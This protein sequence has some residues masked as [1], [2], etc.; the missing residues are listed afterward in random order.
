VVPTLKAGGME[1][2][3]SSLANIFSKNEGLQLYLITLTNQAHFFSLDKKVKFFQP[4]SPRVKNFIF[5]S[6]TTIAFLRR[7]IKKHKPDSILSFGD[8]YNSIVVF[9]GLLSSSKIFISNR[10]NPFQSNGIFI[11]TLNRLLYPYADG[12]ICQTKIA[13]KVFQEKYAIKNFSVIPNPINIQSKTA[14]VNCKRIINVGRFGDQK[15]QFELVEIFNQLNNKEGWQLVFFGDGAKKEKTLSMI[16]SLNLKKTVHIQ[17]FSNSIEKEYL[18]SSIFAFTSK[19]EGFP[20][21]LAEAMS[22]GCACISFDCVAG[23]SDIIDDGVN[24]FLIP[25]DDHEM[26]VVK[27]NELVNNPQLREVMGNAAKNKMKQF[28]SSK[29]SQMYLNFIIEK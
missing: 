15:N 8:R 23:P 20:N 4:N 27:L 14:D 19:S 16:N 28:N 29:I 25:E 9:S 13:A 12:L 11:D 7:L 22:F 21:A 26:Y 24:G 5:Q 3:A 10:Q 2:V 17:P 1:R 6:I 18:K